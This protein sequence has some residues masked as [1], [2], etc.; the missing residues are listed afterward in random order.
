MFAGTQW[1]NPAKPGNPKLLMLFTA[2]AYFGPS[3]N[4]GP[5]SVGSFV[6][7]F[8]CQTQLT[9][10]PVALLASCSISP[11]CL[12]LCGGLILAQSWAWF[13][14]VCRLS[15]DPPNMNFGVSPCLQ[16]WGTPPNKKADLKGTKTPPAPTHPHPLL[17]DKSAEASQEQN[18]VIRNAGRALFTPTPQTRVRR[19][20]RKFARGASGVVAPNMCIYL[21][22]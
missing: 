21:Y 17:P 20:R 14:R 8:A 7:V 2:H 6:L 11:A 22:M 1:T 18:I 5:L 9:L 10:M 15:G 3:S 16:Q 19:H 12:F 13:M 4:R